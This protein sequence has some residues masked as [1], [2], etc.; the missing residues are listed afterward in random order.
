MTRTNAIIDANV[1]FRLTQ[2][3]VLSICFLPVSDP[4]IYVLGILHRDHTD[5]IRLIARE[6]NL[7]LQDLVDGSSFFSEAEISEEYAVA[8]L[9]V[10]AS[11]E[12]PSGVLVLGGQKILFFEAGGSKRRDKGKEKGKGKGKERAPR[13]NPSARTSTGANETEPSPE[14]KASVDWL[15]SDLSA[16]VCRFISH[17]R[18]LMH[19]D[20]FEPVDEDGSRVLLG[21]KYGRLCLLSLM[22]T[23]GEISMRIDHLGEVCGLFISPISDILV[24]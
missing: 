2:L 14:P 12:G 23:G 6:V 17:W 16:Y 20:S 3:N 8:L 4:N 7:D 24:C 11:S 22:R 19:F 18:T 13:G 15:M 9:P 1:F 5:T 21:D 10:P